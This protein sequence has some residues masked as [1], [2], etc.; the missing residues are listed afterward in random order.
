MT[1]TDVIAP[2]RHSVDVPLDAW[3]GQRITIELETRAA[4]PS[5]ETLEMGGWALPRLHSRL[6]GAAP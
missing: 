5:G 4:L 1:T 2:V 3:R 6:A